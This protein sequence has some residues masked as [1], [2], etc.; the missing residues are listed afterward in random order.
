MNIEVDIYFTATFDFKST[1][2]MVIPMAY[3]LPNYITQKQVCAKV[4]NVNQRDNLY[5]S[6]VCIPNA[7]PGFDWL[8]AHSIAGHTGLE[9]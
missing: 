8:F 9:S 3:N 6:I 4:V 7:D 1:R 5:G 2:N